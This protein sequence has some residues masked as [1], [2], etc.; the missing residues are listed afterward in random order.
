MTGYTYSS[1]SNSNHRLYRIFRHC[2]IGYR[3]QSHHSF[4][5]NVFPLIFSCISC[6]LLEYIDI[7]TQKT[8]LT[9]SGGARQAVTYTPT[10]TGQLNPKVLQRKAYCVQAQ[11][12]VAKTAGWKSCTRRCRC[13]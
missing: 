2:C 10:P 3:I 1:Q 9:D 11:Y 12:T 8:L 5:R 4:K 7:M 6:Y 13:D